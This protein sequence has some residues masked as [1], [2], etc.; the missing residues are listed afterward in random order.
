MFAEQRNRFNLH[1]P[2]WTIHRDTADIFNSFMIAY[3]NIVLTFMIVDSGSLID[4][5]TESSRKI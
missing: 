4:Q 5:L 3:K 2:E 1:Y